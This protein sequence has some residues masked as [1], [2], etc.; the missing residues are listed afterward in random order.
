MVTSLDER[1]ILITGNAGKGLA[2]EL[3][4]IWPQATFVSRATGYDLTREEDQDRAVELAS[5]HDV[6]INN[7]ALWRFNQTL[8]LGKLYGKA[9]SQKQNLHIICI[10][11]T[12]DRATGAKNWIY[13][14]EKKA[15]RS[16]CNSLSMLSVW[17]GG[18][19]VSLISFG[20]MEN[21][22]EKHPDRVCL[23]LSA[24]ASYVKWVIDAPSDACINEISI[25]PMQMERWYE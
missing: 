18:P 15:L 24:A 13:Q 9:Q 14:Q 20:T 4:K 6:F 1:R 23:R 5:K 25:D 3:H 19:R 16:Y 21:N 11:S 12:A 22:Q 7:S 2:G 17:S 8:L 10:G